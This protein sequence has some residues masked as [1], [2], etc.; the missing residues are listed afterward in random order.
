[1]IEAYDGTFELTLIVSDT[2]FDNP[3]IWNF[4][5]VEIKF[6]KPLDPSILSSSHKNVQK[7]KMEPHFPPEESP[8]KNLFVIFAITLVISHLLWDTH[9]PQLL[10]LSLP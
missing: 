4:A 3:M 9:G 6:R 10:L 5:K 2:A 1:L 8:T 7:A